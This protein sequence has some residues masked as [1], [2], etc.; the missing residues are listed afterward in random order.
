MLPAGQM[1]IHQRHEARVMRWFQKVR[2]LMHQDVFETFAR[3]LGL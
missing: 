2:Q 1:A 3:L